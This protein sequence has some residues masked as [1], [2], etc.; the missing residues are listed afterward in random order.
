VRAKTFRFALRLVGPLLLAFVV[1]RMPNKGALWSA[2]SDAA[3]GWLLFAAL[4]NGLNI[5]C[6]VLRWRLLL[7][8]LGHRYSNRAAWRSILPSM[9]IGMLTPG[10][11]GDVLRVQYL[12]H[13]LQLSYADG[14]AVIVMDRICDLYVLLAFVVAGVAHYAQAL[15]GDLAW[16][17][18]SAIA[19]CALLPVL[20]LLKGP[21][22]GLLEA[23]Y[24]KVSKEES[25]QGPQRFLQALRKQLGWRLLGA[26]PLT[27][28][29]FGIQ[30]TQGYMASAAMGLDLSL[31]DVTFM[32][33]ITSLLSLL[34]ISMSGVGVR[35]AFL[36]MVFPTL[37]LAASQGVAFGLVMFAVVYL[38]TMAAGFVAWQ[39]VPPPL[40]FRAESQAHV[41]SA[42]SDPTEGET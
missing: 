31:L 41:P 28:L 17:T 21:V 26:V 23:V 42:Q 37:G 24:R 19:A 35:E 36:A 9:Y 27:A 33:A 18:W 8:I 3:W 40:Q 30:Y 1:W 38:A 15:R 29:A 16:F 14:L 22:D 39:L 2:V 5:H 25:G 12:R 32:L 34:P 6:K 10:R 4:C 11:V 20:L 13:D 7:H